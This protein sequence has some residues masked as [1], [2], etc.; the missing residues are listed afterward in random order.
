VRERPSVSTVVAGDGRFELAGVPSGSVS[1]QFKRDGRLAGD[2][3]IRS[4][5]TNQEIRIV[6][7]LTQN[8]EV[9]LLEEKR[10]QV[11]FDENEC[12][13]GAGFWCRNQDGKNPN[14]TAEEFQKFAAAA[15]ERLSSVPALDTS[16]EIAAAVCNTSDQLLRQLAALAL[17]LAAGTITRETPLIDEPYPNVGAAFDAAVQ[18]AVEGG[19]RDE[20]NQIK[21]VIERINE[22]RN[23]EA[24]DDAEPDDGEDDGDG[25]PPP[26]GKITICHIPPGNP[27]ARHT[28][29]IDSSAWPAHKAHGDYMGPCK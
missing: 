16:E 24:C 4:V 21:D 5:R 20:R 28:I 3:R 22:N 15:A 14:L 7:A 19:S 11:S 18:V 13:R 25:A 2:I 27:S 26:T 10:D 12:P 17:N 9:V 1:V 8:D 6:V 23:H 29:T